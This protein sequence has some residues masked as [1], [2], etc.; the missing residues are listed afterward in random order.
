M[1][2]HAAA[3]HPEAKSAQAKDTTPGRKKSK[4][5]SKKKKKPADRQRQATAGP[6]QVA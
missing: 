5:K 4:G 2:V 1:T 6:P 3:S